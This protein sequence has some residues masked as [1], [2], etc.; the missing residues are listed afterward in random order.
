MKVSARSLVSP[1]DFPIK[2]AAGMLYCK[3]MSPARIVEWML[4]DS[5]KQKMYWAP[6]HIGEE[7]PD[8]KFLGFIE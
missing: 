4:V 3:L 5:L 8:Q 6:N 2:V 7:N 1:L